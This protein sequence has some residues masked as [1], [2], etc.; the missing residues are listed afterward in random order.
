MGLSWKCAVQYVQ[1]PGR[2]VSAKLTEYQQGK[3]LINNN[4]SLR[5]VPTLINLIANPDWIFSINW[6]SLIDE[7]HNMIYYIHGR[8]LRCIK[9]NLSN[10]LTS[11]LM[12]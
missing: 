4:I 12:G 3:Y 6:I 8:H 7:K 9:C 5:N 2:V 1:V 10:N 11:G